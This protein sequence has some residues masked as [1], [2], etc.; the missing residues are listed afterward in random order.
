VLLV[1]VARVF[2]VPRRRSERR[3]D[4]LKELGWTSRRR[5][6]RC[7]RVSGMSWIGCRIHCWDWIPDLVEEE[8]GVELG[9]LAGF[10]EKLTVAVR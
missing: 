10:G 6:R 1:S 4:S 9:L 3:R 7:S 8:G 5:M 2:R